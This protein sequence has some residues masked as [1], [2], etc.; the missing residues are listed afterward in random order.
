MPK[1]EVSVQTQIK[2]R[3]LNADFLGRHTSLF[4][5]L[6]KLRKQYKQQ[7]ERCL[8]HLPGDFFS[9]GMFHLQSGIHLNEVKL[10]ITIQKKFHGASILIAN[11]PGQA[12]C[13][14]CHCVSNAG[15]KLWGW[16]NLD[17]FL[18]SSLDRTVSFKEMDN[19][20]VFIT[21]KQEQECKELKKRD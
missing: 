7:Y 5:R 18:M 20:A 19:I 3:F 17:N 8:E 12:D 1:T 21:W 6:D 2:P 15:I 9:N 10:S 14:G 13:T 4:G 16:G 11:M